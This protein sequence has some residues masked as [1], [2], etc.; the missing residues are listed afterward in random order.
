MTSMIKTLKQ[1]N[2][3]STKSKRNTEIIINYKATTKLYG[4]IKATFLYTQIK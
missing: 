4:T 2:R 3:V 1:R